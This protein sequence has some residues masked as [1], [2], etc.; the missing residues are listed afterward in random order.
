MSYCSSVFNS[1]HKSAPKYWQ[2]SLYKTKFSSIYRI[3]MLQ[4][5]CLFNHWTVVEVFLAHL[6]NVRMSEPVSDGFVTFW[7]QQ[8][9]EH[10]HFYAKTIQAHKA[11]KI[12]RIWTSL[13]SSR[14][15]ILHITTSISS[16]VYKKKK[17]T[18]PQNT[19]EA[20]KEILLYEI[21]L[22]FLFLQLL[23]VTPVCANR[24]L[25]SLQVGWTEQ[26]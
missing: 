9:S 16:L 12:C 20:F 10:T 23:C 2:Y 14:F 3:F 8:W 25:P 6:S 11:G 24:L 21:V 18:M 5:N 26:L 15:S 4:M 22:L 1:V 13:T 7:S 19:K 17:N